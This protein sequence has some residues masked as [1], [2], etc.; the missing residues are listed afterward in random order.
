MKYTYGDAFDDFAAVAHDS[1]SFHYHEWWL[2]DVAVV[3]SR[4]H[5]V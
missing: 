5:S 4:D 2:S 1:K 3:V